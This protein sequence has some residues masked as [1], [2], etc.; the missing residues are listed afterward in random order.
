M[1]DIRKIFNLYD[2]SE[3]KLIKLSDKK[4]LYP[5]TISAAGCLFYKQTIY[6]KQLLLTKYVD[7]HWPRLDDFGGRVDVKDN[8]IYD[9]IIRETN[10]ETNGVI[11]ETRIRELVMNPKNKHYYNRESKYYLILVQVDETFFPDTTVFGQ[12][13][14]H[15]QIYRTIDWYDIYSNRQNLSMRLLGDP[16]LMKD[17]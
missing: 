3:S 9:T 2:L 15:D 14:N 17:L 11:G 7:P 8:T 4:N 5:C 13:E 12:L 1:E 6:G 16:V 10:E